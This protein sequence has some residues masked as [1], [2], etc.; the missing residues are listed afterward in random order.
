MTFFKND[1]A[2]HGMPTQVFWA[3]FGLPKIPKCL[4]IGL[5]WHTN[6]FKNGSNFKTVLLH[7][8]CLVDPLWHPPLWATSCSLPQPTGPRYGDPGVS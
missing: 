1:L 2:P 7:T 6:C 4:E 3:G 5:F 8:L